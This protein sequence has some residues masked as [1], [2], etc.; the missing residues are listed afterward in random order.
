[1]PAGCIIS[2]G[3][4]NHSLLFPQVPTAGG[5]YLLT[6]ATGRKIAGNL[7][8]NPPEF[9]D[10]QRGV[11]RYRQANDPRRRKDRMAVGVP[12]AVH[13]RCGVPALRRADQLLHH[14]RVLDDQRGDEQLH[15][16]HRL[17]GQP[18]LRGRRL[19]LTH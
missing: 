14:E 12:L 5:L 10:G 4:V 2:G 8:R 19:P 16:G 7:E 18:E 11:F 17:H 9:Q 3:Y 1:M 13:D 6:D 15:V